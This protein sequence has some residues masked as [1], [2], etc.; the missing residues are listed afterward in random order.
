ME[1]TGTEVTK[2][3][4]RCQEK[5]E[6]QHWK[7]PPLLL[8][9][10]LMELVTLGL[11]TIHCIAHCHTFGT[12]LKSSYLKM[13]QRATEEQARKEAEENERIERKYKA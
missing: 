6:L 9:L 11:L 5:C 1:T 2:N 10:H 3:W 4:A 12:Y 13:R 8:G 7:L